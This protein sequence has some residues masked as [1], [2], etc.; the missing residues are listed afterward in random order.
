M[1][2]SSLVLAK[3]PPVDDAAKA[4]AAETAAKAAWQGKVDAYKLCQ[5]QDRVA[6]QY[7][8]G[9]ASR[10]AVNV[11]AAAT[12]PTAAANPGASAAAAVPP[13]P[14]PASPSNAAN[15]PAASQGGG[16]PAPTVAAAPKIPPC[17]D[18]GPFAYNPPQ[19]TPLE[20]SG[21]HSPPGNAASPPSVKNHSA[22]MAPAGPASAQSKKP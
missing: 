3:L 8:K 5:A 1:A 19:Q 22:E 13:S 7:R 15:T 12:V 2:A 21:A 9:A 4:K 16:T 18:P 11:P 17:A 14:T 20:A 6:A 10:P